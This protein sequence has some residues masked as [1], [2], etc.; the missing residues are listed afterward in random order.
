M[1]FEDA[2]LFSGGEAGVEREDLDVMQ[3]V[4]KMLLDFPDF[5]FAG[6]KAEN[7]AWGLAQ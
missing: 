6:Q 7:V 1:A 5:P 3:G 2:L 4:A